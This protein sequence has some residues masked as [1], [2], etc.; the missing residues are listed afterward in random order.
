MTDK[1]SQEL[2]EKIKARLNQIEIDELHG[3]LPPRE[4]DESI[5]DWLQRTILTPAAPAKTAEFIVFNDKKKELKPVITLPE[6]AQVFQMRARKPIAFDLIECFAAA[7]GELCK[8]TRRLQTEELPIELTITPEADFIHVMAITLGDPNREKYR[9]KTLEITNN[10]LFDVYQVNIP[11][12]ALACGEINLPYDDYNQQLLFD[13][14]SA[15][16]LAIYD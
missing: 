6:L 5:R 14:E 3:A 8:E 9:D 13:P 1:R 11:F 4:D 7:D 12:D 16:I 2:L 15:F 10:A